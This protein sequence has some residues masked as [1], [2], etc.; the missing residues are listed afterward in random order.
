VIQTR[1]QGEERLQ[2]EVEDHNAYLE[3]L[4]AYAKIPYLTS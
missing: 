1:E 3:N 2:G 4:V